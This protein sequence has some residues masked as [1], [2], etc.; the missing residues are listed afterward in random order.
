MFRHRQFVE[1]PIFDAGGHSW[2]LMLFPKGVYKGYESH[3]GVFLQLAASRGDSRLVRARPW[4]SLLDG[5]GKPAVSRDARV[6][7]FCNLHSYACY[8]MQDFITREELEGS[9]CLGDDCFSIQ[10]D[11]DVITTVHK[12]HE[13]P[14]PCAASVVPSPSQ[15]PP[16]STIAVSEASGYHVL[17]IDGYTRTTMMVT[18]DEHLDSGEFHARRRPCQCE[19]QDQLARSRAGEPV[20]RYSQSVDKCSISKITDR[21][22]CKSFIKRDKLEKS[23]HVV[24]DRFAVRCDLTFNVQDLPVT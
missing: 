24:G 5:A 19:C 17:K 9:E 4:F 23:G 6:Y 16:C 3:I 14:K 21:W 12:G 11:V 18:T 20:A 15:S 10:C 2:R 7:D 8:G 13:H 1:S 22:V